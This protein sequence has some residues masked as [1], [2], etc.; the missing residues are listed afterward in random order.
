MQGEDR[1]HH[2]GLTPAERELEDALRGLRPS[3]SRIRRDRL[4]FD[5]GVAAGAAT[6]RAWPRAL[7]LVAAGLAIGAG[8]SIFWPL[9][10][11][12][13]ERVGHREAPASHPIQVAQATTQQ[14]VA[15]HEGRTVQVAQASVGERRAPAGERPNTPE[16]KPVPIPVPTSPFVTVPPRFVNMSRVQFESDVRSSAYL[17]A[18]QN[19]LERGFEAIP[20]TRTTPADVRPVNPSTPDSPAPAAPAVP[21]TGALNP[22]YR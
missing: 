16:L 3:P 7:G 20:S 14:E 4:H 8:L 15:T 10:H 17:S 13:V 18:I 6:S 21:A 2:P 12:A 22:S 11:R 19:V 9:E 1:S 5:A